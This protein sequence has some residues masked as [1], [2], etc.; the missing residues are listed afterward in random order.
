MMLINMHTWGHKSK[1]GKGE[2][3]ARM[4]KARNGHIILQQPWNSYIYST[5]TNIRVF[6]SSLRTVL[7]YGVECF[8]MRK[9]E[10]QRCRTF[11][12]EFI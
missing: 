9:S 2:I 12:N 1:K 7:L 10:T 3:T 8:K 5:T 6:K 4:I 11:Q